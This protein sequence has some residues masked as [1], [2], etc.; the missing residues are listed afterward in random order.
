MDEEYRKELVRYLSDLEKKGK[1]DS[2]KGTIYFEDLQLAGYMKNIPIDIDL[3]N[4]DAVVKAYKKDK[5]LKNFYMTKAAVSR[6]VEASELYGGSSI[7]FTYVNLD[8]DKL[9]DYYEDIFG[10]DEY[11]EY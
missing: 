7:M 9:W 2:I 10:E 3:D 11:D 4:G 1:L 5:T 8:D 6:F